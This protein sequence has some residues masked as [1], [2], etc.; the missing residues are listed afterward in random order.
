MAI[1]CQDMTI[2]VH[3]STVCTQ[4]P[5]FEAAMNGNFKEAHTRTINLPDDDTATIE[6]VLCFLYCGYYKADGHVMNLKPGCVEQQSALADQPLEDADQN[7]DTDTDSLIKEKDDASDQSSGSKEEMPS[8]EQN[9]SSIAYVY[10]KVYTAADKFGITELKKHTAEKFRN[11]CHAN[12][13]A[14]GFSQVIQ[15]ATRMP[16]PPPSHDLIMQHIAETIARHPVDLSNND[17]ISAVIDS[18]GILCRYIWKFSVELDKYWRPEKDI[19]DGHVMELGPTKN[20]NKDKDQSQQN[21][22]TEK[23]ADNDDQNTTHNPVHP[24]PL[25]QKCHATNKLLSRP[26]HMS[27][28]T[29]TSPPTKFPK[30]AR[31]VLDITTPLATTTE[32]KNMITLIITE[33]VAHLLKDETISALVATSPNLASSVLTTLIKGDKQ[34]ES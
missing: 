32:I 11:W 14:V 33:N 4:S 10:L 25:N 28:Y 22:I 19:W 30:V 15:V 5:F 3:R 23:Q 2:K 18:N 24:L 17:Q 34:K 29:P 7:T 13:N 31:D 20:K 9:K 27:T 21:T 26:Q 16:L 8:Q 1:T 6:R 12:W